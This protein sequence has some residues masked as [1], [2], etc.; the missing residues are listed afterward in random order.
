MNPRYDED[1]PFYDEKGYMWSKWLLEQYLLLNAVDY[2]TESQNREIDMIYK[3]AFQG[4]EVL[5]K[6][7]ME[8]KNKYRQSCNK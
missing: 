7:E 5:N 3:A 8:L 1:P 4:R 2:R 6:L